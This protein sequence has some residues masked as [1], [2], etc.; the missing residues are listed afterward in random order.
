M[1]IA[2]IWYGLT[3]RYGI[4]RD[5]L[6]GAM[7]ILEK[8]YQV[9]YHEP[10]DEIPEDAIVLYW[11]APCSI[12]GKD[13]DQYLR[14]K[15]LPNKKILLFAGG[16]IKAEWLSGFDHVCVES[17]I[18]SVELEL[19]GIPHSTAFGINEDMFKPEKQPKIFDAAVFGTCASW[20][21]QGIISKA[22]KDR[23]VIAGRF[24]EEDPSPFIESRDAG[25]LV[26]EEQT[27]ITLNSLLNASHCTVNGAE[28]WGGGQRVTLE[29]M[30]AGIPVICM[31]DSPKNKEYVEESGAGLVCE[32]NIESIRRTVEEIKLWS[33]EDKFKGYEYVRSKWTKQHYADA[34][35]KAI[36]TL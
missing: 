6:W 17:K 12:N 27:P 20:K 22:L 29:S 30:S 5:G 28:F 15:N 16:P 8:K 35:K 32:P 23:V 11:E 36:E 1:K 24:Q 18:N 13:R 21:R 4:W 19:L 9:T 10:S 2:F 14:V 25:A 33:E 26:L 7:K 3:G 34:L 31:S